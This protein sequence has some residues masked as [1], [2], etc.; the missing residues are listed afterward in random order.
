MLHLIRLLILT[1]TLWTVLPTNVWAQDLAEVPVYRLPEG[2]RVGEQR[3]YNLGEFREL[4]RIDTELAEAQETIALQ[5]Q[6]L[7]EQ[8][9][10]ISNLSDAHE[11]AS[12][13]VELLQQERT[14]LRVQWEEENR[15][16]YEAEA[17]PDVL[18]WVGWAA[19][20]VAAVTAVALGVTLA[21]TQ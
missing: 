5:Q 13:Q 20:A 16:R 11:A 4:L 14:R 10:I 18:G 3:C 9:R 8:D 15:Q 6:S 2:R 7:E 1:T 12:A 21:V 19:A 17:S